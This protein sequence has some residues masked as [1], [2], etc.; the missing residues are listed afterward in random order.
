MEGGQ[1]QARGN[2]P[3][4]DRG[5]PA[6]PF[7]AD[8]ERG[9]PGAARPHGGGGRGGGGGHPADQD[10]GELDAVQSEQRRGHGR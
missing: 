1:Q 3:G 6:V 2:R 8:G 9:Q 10:P 5:Q 7:L 4:T